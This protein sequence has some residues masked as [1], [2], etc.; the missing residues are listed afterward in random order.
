MLYQ[1]VALW[2][3][4]RTKEKS[5]YTDGPRGIQTVLKAI[6]KQVKTELTRQPAKHASRAKRELDLAKQIGL[7]EDLRLEQAGLAM[8][9]HD[10]ESTKRRYHEI[11]TFQLGTTIHLTV[12]H[13]M[14]A[15]TL[16]NKYEQRLT[17]YTKSLVQALHERKEND[18]KVGN[19]R[20]KR[21]WALSTSIS[22]IV[23]GSSRNEP[24]QW[25]QSADLVEI[26]LTLELIEHQSSVL[27][28]AASMDGNSSVQ[29]LAGSISLTDKSTAT[30][31]AERFMNGVN[32]ITE[33]YQILTKI[34]MLIRDWPD[35]DEMDIVIAQW[36][37]S[38]RATLSSEYMAHI[39]IHAEG[40]DQ[41]GDAVTCLTVAIEISW[42]I[43]AMCNG[44]RNEMNPKH[45]YDS[46]IQEGSQDTPLSQWQKKVLR[47]KNR[48]KDK[49]KP[50]IPSLHEDGDGFYVA[51]FGTYADTFFAARSVVMQLLKAI[52]SRKLILAVRKKEKME[53]APSVAMSKAEIEAER[54]ENER[55]EK[56]ILDDTDFISN[57][58]TVAMKLSLASLDLSQLVLTP[59]EGVFCS[60]RKVGIGDYRYIE[61]G[62]RCVTEALKL[63]C[64]I[65]VAC[66]SE[67]PYGSVI[68]PDSNSTKHSPAIAQ[69]AARSASKGGSPQKALNLVTDDEMI[70]SGVIYSTD[71]SEILWIRCYMLFQTCSKLCIEA[72]DNIP[73][74]SSLNQ[75]INTIALFILQEDARLLHRRQ[76]AKEE[77]SQ[78]KPVEKV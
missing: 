72:V 78:L 12:P 68:T 75:C 53:K 25:P 5:K 51:V 6:D 33:A 42:W 43:R 56:A 8:L 31:C 36:F 3:A 15:S 34:L 39:D 38:F 2:D 46:A 64:S 69:A 4:K 66:M 59:L 76:A 7:I 57:A 44:K 61:T 10:G 45:K 54:L 41:D 32:R 40:E 19:E 13:E 18:I 21:L 73:M 65:F 67:R 49:P 14:K 20:G 16:L 71:E 60:V 52:S 48:G 55:A 28:I 74:Q 27:R 29:S 1:E 22:N 37:K 30:D 58:L 23:G 11:R 47:Q 9:Y 77:L 63:V 35:E 26:L 50:R 24:L 62:E 17:G 70:E